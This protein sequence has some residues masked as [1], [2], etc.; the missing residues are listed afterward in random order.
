[1]SVAN[2]ARAQEGEGGI[3]G[4]EGAKGGGREMW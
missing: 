4:F 1:M 2:G 3:P